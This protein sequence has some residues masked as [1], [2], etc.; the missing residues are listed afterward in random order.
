MFVKIHKATRIVVAVCDSDLIGRK[1]EDEKRRLE[2]SEFFFKDERKDEKELRDLFLFYR[3]E[4]ACFNIVGEKSCN[5]AK[6]SGLITDENIDF[7]DKIPFSL[8]LS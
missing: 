7:I 5:V 4:D 8:I 6:K 1:F 3:V 2:P